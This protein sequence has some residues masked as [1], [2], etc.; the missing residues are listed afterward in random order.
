M[1]IEQGL[2]FR[3]HVTECAKVLAFWHA[4]MIPQRW[5]GLGDGGDVIHREFWR[6]LRGAL[7]RISGH[8]KKLCRQS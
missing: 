6:S 8:Q 7:L 3:D 2:G 1:G 5:N 4:V